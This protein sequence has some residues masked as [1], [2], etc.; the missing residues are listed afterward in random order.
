MSPNIR[1]TDAER[2]A[3]VRH[4]PSDTTTIA[5]DLAETLGDS[6]PTVRMWLARVVAK[7]ALVRLKTGLYTRP[8]IENT[9]PGPAAVAARVETTLDDLDWST[10]DWTQ[11][12]K[13][14]ARQTG[15][16]EYSVTRKRLE[17][18]IPPSLELRRAQREAKAAQARL[19]LQEQR[20]A[21]IAQWREEARTRTISELADLWGLTGPG[22]HLRVKAYGFEH[23]L[24]KPGSGVRIRIPDDLVDRVRDAAKAAETTSSAWVR[25]VLEEALAEAE[26][27]L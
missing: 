7:G 19:L 4:W 10:V 9:A 1:R 20:A 23:R 5:K 27:Q 15:A 24:A 17:L 2:I 14:I 22:A 6:A 18:G 26:G 8:G 25:R 3:A 16:S 13:G 21:R 11:S 12:D